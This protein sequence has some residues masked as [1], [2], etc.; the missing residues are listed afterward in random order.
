MK[1]NLRIKT[2]EDGRAMLNLGCGTKMNWTWNNMDLSPYAHLA[3]HKAIA[4]ILRR[5]GFLSE[6]R[7]QDFLCVDPEMIYRDLRYGIPFPDESFDVVYHSHLLEHIDRDLVPSFLKDCYR[8]LKRG[9]YLRI[10]VPDLLAI[11][12]RYILAISKLEGGDESALNDYQ[13]A[14][15][16]LFDQM[17]RRE[18]SGRKQQRPLVRAIE[19]FLLGD[20]AKTGELHRW[21]Y[22]KYSLRALLSSIGFRDVREEGPFTSRIDGWSQFKLDSNGD[23][24]VYKPGSLYMEAVK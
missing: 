2:V 20:A 10:V 8:L 13:R 22:D 5:I 21:M 16:D 6:K 24:T 3:R 9:G 23:G 4:K 7:Y 14:T 15:D 12:N 19:R 1:H 18:P 17:V 11:M